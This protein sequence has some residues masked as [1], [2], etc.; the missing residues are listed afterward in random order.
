MEEATY[1]SLVEYDSIL[2]SIYESLCECVTEDKLAKIS[3]DPRFEQAKLAVLFTIRSNTYFNFLGTPHL[4]LLVPATINLV[5]GTKNIMWNGTKY[6]LD[7]M[8]NP[9]V[10]DEIKKYIE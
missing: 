6:H 7:P 4:L 8:A 1:Q 3:E 5:L 10:V 9:A 2:K